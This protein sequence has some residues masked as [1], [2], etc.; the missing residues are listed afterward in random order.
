MLLTRNELSQQV[1]QKGL[2]MWQVRMVEGDG[3]GL[4]RHL[5]LGSNPTSIVDQLGDLR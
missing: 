3:H 2:E 4:W 5:T 1:S